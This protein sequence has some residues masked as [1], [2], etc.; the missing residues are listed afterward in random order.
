MKYSAVY[1]KKKYKSC[2]S[3]QNFICAIKSY[4]S[5]IKILEI[6]MNFEKYKEYKSKNVKCLMIQWY[7]WDEFAKMKNI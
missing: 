4:W 7:K 5:L 3:S 6:Q 1:L 2:K